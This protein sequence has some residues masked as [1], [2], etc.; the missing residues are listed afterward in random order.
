[1]RVHESFVFLGPGWHHTG[2]S[3]AMETIPIGYFGT[4]QHK[5]E[6]NHSCNV[7]ERGPLTSVL[8]L[9]EFDDTMISSSMNH[10]AYVDSLVHTSSSFGWTHDKDTDV[11]Y[12][13]GNYSLCRE[14]RVQIQYKAPN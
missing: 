2:T 3:V 14:T 7:G 12:L 4:E 13:C 1:M 8:H 10:R 11:Q 6:A 5:Q 9:C